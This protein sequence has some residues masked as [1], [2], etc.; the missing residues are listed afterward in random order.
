MLTI[1]YSKTFPTSMVSHIDMLRVVNRIM[2]R[3]GLK[4]EYSKGFNPHMLIFFSPPL[5]LGA[6]SHA[7]YVSV[8]AD[9]TGFSL[10]E[11]NKVCPLGIEGS[12]FFITAKSP[13]LAA[14]ITSAKY[15]ITGKNVGALDFDGIFAGEKYE[16]S[17]ME[18][19]EE[20]TKDVKSFIFNVKVIDGNTIEATLACGN[21]NL[22]AD[23]F[24][25]GV[26][27][28]SGKE[29]SDVEILKTE[30]FVKEINADEFL[31]EKQE[32]FFAQ[33]KAASTEENK[34]QE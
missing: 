22:K 29:I 1:K 7:E 10:E 12:D 28:N 14:E 23:R 17:Y 15:L 20:V 24:I 30:A 31:R 4:T 3:A 6:E 9:T 8:A 21:K 16:I 13:N 32:E 25:N 2:R 11:F 5:S 18:K 19:G 27:K 34:E 26:A 33:M